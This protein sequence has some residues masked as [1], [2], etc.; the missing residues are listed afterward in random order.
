A[1]DYHCECLPKLSGRTCSIL[2]SQ[3]ASFLNISLM[4]LPVLIGS[5]TGIILLII[6]IFIIRKCCMRRRRARAQIINETHKEPVLLNSVRPHELTELKRSSKLSNLEVN[7][8]DA[9]VMPPRPVSYT[10]SS[11]NEPT[12]NWN[13]VVLNN[14]DTLRSYHWDCSDWVRRSQ[15]PLPNI[16][17]VPGS[18]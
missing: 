12:Y 4:E 16:T 11:H 1:G 17:E 3:P 6:F 10:P 13:S 7:R 14:L 5:V 9:P 15:N 18:E 8:R 2:L